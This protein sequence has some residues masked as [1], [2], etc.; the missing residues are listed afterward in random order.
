MRKDYEFTS[1]SVSEGHPDKVCDQI[2]DAILDRFL[3]ADPDSK[4]AVETLVTKNRI[5]L[6]GE[7]RAREDVVI[8]NDEMVEI[9]R[10]VV[11]KIGY[12]DK[13]FNL[14]DIEVNC[15]VHPQSVEINQAVVKSDSAGQTENEKKAIGAGDQGI[16][17]GYA[18]KE[19]HT[20]DQGGEYM[21][22][23][24]YYAHKIVKELADLRH[25][26]A[27][28]SLRPD[29]KSQVTLKY[30]ND[31]PVRA[32][33]IV[34]S[35]QHEKG[36]SLRGDIEAVVRKI[37]PEGWFPENREDFLFNPSGSFIDGGPA[38]DTGLTGRKII[39]DT[40]G[41]A[42][43]H[44]G[45]AFSGKDPTKVD[46]SAAYAARH[47]AKNVVAAGIAEKCL[48][49]LSYA[50]GVAEPQSLYV[51]TTGSGEVN[52]KEVTRYLRENVDLTP[53]GIL[54][55]LDLR[56]PMYLQTAAYGHFGRPG[57]NEAFTWEQTDLVEGLKREFGS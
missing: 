52:D 3:A 40:Y 12:D 36:A 20:D 14:R 39:V 50:I 55:R 28:S 57:S 25:S 5:V 31:K 13:G 2:S 48:I 44:G 16:M 21:P 37:L 10:E 9:A 17:F 51:K 4:V 26:G 15:Y 47:L 18:T 43:P 22:A 19:S 23:P 8:T 24:I 56:K 49:Q 7:V 46:R 11:Q 27:I 1:E 6:A 53:A 29:A 42:A 32:T 54:K 33:K 38:C 35:T 34:V 41:G 45:G 30:E